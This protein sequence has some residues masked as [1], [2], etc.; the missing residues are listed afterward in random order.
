M[1][2]AWSAWQRSCTLA[3]TL[4]ASLQNPADNTRPGHLRGR[5]VVSALKTVEFDMREPPGHSASM[6][7][8]P[9]RIDHSSRDCLDGVRCHC[10][11]GRP[12]AQVVK[13]LAERK[14]DSPLVDLP[15]GR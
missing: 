14:V 4:C 3:L 7:L 9:E 6:R 15:C 1:L 2:V 11:H 12:A 5:H 13:G 10:V 8:E